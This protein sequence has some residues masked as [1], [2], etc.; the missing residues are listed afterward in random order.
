MRMF[1][2]MK[3]ARPSSHIRC[4]IASD[5]NPTASEEPNRKPKALAMKVRRVAAGVA[6]GAGRAYSGLAGI[7]GMVSFFFPSATGWLLA[8]A[9]AFVMGPGL[10]PLRAAAKMLAV[11]FGA[12]AAGADGL[13]SA[14]GLAAA[15]FAAAARLA[16]PAGFG[17]TFAPG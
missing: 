6:A 5:E 8:A 17:A 12:A 2:N 14:A 15:G 16:A 9:S 1:G 7:G 10:A 11:S 3:R 13:A 4:V